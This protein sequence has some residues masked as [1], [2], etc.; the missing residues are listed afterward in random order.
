M[1]IVSH[2]LHPQ[3]PCP[4][5]LYQAHS[6]MLALRAYSYKVETI[7]DA[8]MVACGHEDDTPNHALRLLAFAREMLR[9][10]ETVTDHEGNPIQLRIGLNSGPAYGGVVGTR[11]PRYCFF[12]DTVNTASRMESTGVPSR[13]QLSDSCKLGWRAEFLTAG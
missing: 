1:H 10:A 13:I 8:Y 7:G 5:E 2:L 6:L 3:I 9:V 4:P 12:G 11:C